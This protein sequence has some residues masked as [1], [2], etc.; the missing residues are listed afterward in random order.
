ML[1]ISPFHSC[2][3]LLMEVR[4]PKHS[5]DP[6][7]VFYYALGPW[8]RRTLCY[9]YSWTSAGCEADISKTLNNPISL[10]ASQIVGWYKMKAN[11]RKLAVVERGETPCVGFKNIHLTQIWVFEVFIHFVLFL[12]YRGLPI[13]DSSLHNLVVQLDTVCTWNP[14]YYT[15]CYPT[16]L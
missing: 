16:T 10:C 1:M 6:F 15:T 4:P 12:N 3:Y 14:T 9:K 13:H 5:R 11:H 2:G 8:H 7:T